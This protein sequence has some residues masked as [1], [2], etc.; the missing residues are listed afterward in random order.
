[1]TMAMS[2]KGEFGRIRDFLAPLAGDG[3]FGLT[4][5]AAVIAPSPVSELVVTTDTVVAGVH[6]IGDE[7]AR[8]IAAKL[9]RVNLSDLAAMGAQPRAYTLNFAL[10]AAIE[11]DW[12]ADFCTGL[13]EDQ[14]RFGIGLLGGDSVS[15]PGPA[16]LTATLFGEAPVGE[17]LRRNGARAGDTVY[18]SGAVGDAAYGLMALQGGLADLEEAHRAALIARYRLPQPRLA[19]GMALRGRATAAADVSDGLVADLGH[20]AEASG[21]AASIRLADVPLSDAGRA[22]AALADDGKVAALIGGDDYELV[23]TGPAGLD[24]S[25]G[26]G[27]VPVTAIGEVAEGTGVAVIGA[28][29]DPVAL[30]RTGWRHN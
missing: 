29:G 30:E 21:V 7:P 17:A 27:S 2:A 6:Y 20:I 25:F 12:V 15:T 8:E 26:G 3:A 11:D 10:P 28:D 5:D 1:M 4:D 13:A 16:T 18:V 19:L 22:A 14:Q 9:L 24:R 23:F